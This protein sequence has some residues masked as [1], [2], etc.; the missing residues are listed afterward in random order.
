MSSYDQL[1]RSFGGSGS[2]LFDF[3]FDSDPE[4]TASDRIRSAVSV[5]G[6]LLYD[7]GNI[8][9]GRD[10]AATQAAMELAAKR[11]RLAALQASELPADIAAPVDG[12][13]PRRAPGA[14]LGA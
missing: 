6:N 13:V 7:T 5:N 3:G 1:V 10:S 4:G 12:I 9:T 14:R 2:A 8:E 11:A